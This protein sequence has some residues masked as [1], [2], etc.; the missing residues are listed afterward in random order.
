[1]TLYYNPKITGAGSVFQ[2]W[3]PN[4]LRTHWIHAWW[5]QIVRQMRSWRCWTDLLLRCQHWWPTIWKWLHL[6]FWK[7]W[8]PLGQVQH[9]WI[10][11]RNG[12]LC[13]HKL[14]FCST[15]PEG[16]CVYHLWIHPWYQSLI[17]LRII[18]KSCHLAAPFVI[19]Y[20]HMSINIGQ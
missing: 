18:T 15:M 12:L 10:Q 2:C 4:S 17:D 13:I 6:H 3:W 19:V 20:F 14:P 11:R 9:V 16:N 7:W 8:L 1:M 5:R